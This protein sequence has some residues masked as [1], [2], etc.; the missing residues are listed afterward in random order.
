MNSET[1]NTADHKPMNG[2]PWVPHA[3]TLPEPAGQGVTRRVLAYGDECM[4]VENT[5]EKGGIGAMHSHP[6]TQITYVVSGRF[7]FTIGDETREVSAGDTLLKQ[8]G[9]Q[10]G[11]VCLEAGILVDFFTPMRK[12]FV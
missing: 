12:D 10:H 1:M 9:V 4:C 6:H 11:C 8:N 7:R 5:F 2:Q 3:E